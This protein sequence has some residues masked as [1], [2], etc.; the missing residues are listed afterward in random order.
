MRGER[1]SAPLWFLGLA[2][3]VLMVGA[4]SA[5]LWRALG[6]RQEMVAIADA[7]AVAAAS[8][9]DLEHYRATGQLRIDPEE[10]AA[11]AL[12]VIDGH[13][14]SADLSGAPLIE[15]AADG[16]SVTVEVMREVPF[17]LLRMLSLS[18]DRF[19]VSGVAVAYPHSP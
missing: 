7:G 10:A 3:C 1:G 15:V 8:V 18:D 12:V 13:S 2:L 4:M 19:V 16:S 17:G 11:R 14:G 5:E 9:I 6:E